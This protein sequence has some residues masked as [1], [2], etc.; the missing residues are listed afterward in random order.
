M[1]KTYRFLAVGVLLVLHVTGAE[2]ITFTVLN[3]LDSGAG[4]LRQA[5]SSA[6]GA[7]GPDNIVFNIPGAGPHRITISSTALVVTDQVVIDGFT[8][9][10][11]SANTLATGNNA[12]L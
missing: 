1:G 4:S 9:P 6:N 11:S 3:T 2:A 8:Q 7:S 5:I 10:G 12:V